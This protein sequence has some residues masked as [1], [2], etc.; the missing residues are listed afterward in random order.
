MAIDINGDGRDDILWRNRG[1][2]AFTTW[3]TGPGGEFTANDAASY[4]RVPGE[5]H[6]W[7]AGDFDGDGYGD[8]L[9]MSAGA[10]TNWLGTAAGSFIAND[11][12]AYTPK[13]ADGYVAATGDFDGDGRDDL[14]MRD[15]NGA[16]QVWFASQ[17]GGFVPDSLRWTEPELAS[18]SVVGTGDFDGDGYDDLLWRREDGLLTQWMGAITGFDGAGQPVHEVDLSW[19]VAGTGDFDGDGLD[20]ILWRRGDGAVTNWLGTTD[21]G[22]A[23]NDRAALTAPGGLD[24]RVVDTGDYDGDGRDDILW[25]RDDGAITHWTALANGGFAAY[26]NAFEVVSTDWLVQPNP[27]GAGE[28]DY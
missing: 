26:G 18:W 15:L 28:W 11:A 12:S 8:V 25:R 24:W 20:D 23:A 19:Q 14:L 1:D 5:W 21:G 9:W 2:L 3:L 10:V 13:P 22:F 4:F 16:V 27:S 6:V 7:G 17:S